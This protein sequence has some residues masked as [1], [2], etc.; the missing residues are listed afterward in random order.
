MR[1]GWTLGPEEL[2][3]L[4]SHTLTSTKIL[5]VASSSMVSILGNAFLKEALNHFHN[6]L[7]KLPHP[8]KPMRLNSV[9]YWLTVV[10]LMAVLIFLCS[11][12]LPLESSACMTGAISSTQHFSLGQAIDRWYGRQMFLNPYSQDLDYIKHPRKELVF[13]VTYTFRIWV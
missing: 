8:C 10:S 11:H 2:S 4:L 5:E 9:S 3:W 1:K 13:S 6:S 12:L 7:S